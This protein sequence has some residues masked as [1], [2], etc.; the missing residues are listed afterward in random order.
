MLLGSSRPYPRLILDENGRQAENDDW[1]LMDTNND[2][3]HSSEQI[4][5][6]RELVDEQRGRQIF[7]HTVTVV[8]V[9]YRRRC[10]HL[11]ALSY[12]SP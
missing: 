8:N 2:M 12:H 6:A 10:K 9:Y 5:L 1:I 11:C 3:L 7:Q 4:L